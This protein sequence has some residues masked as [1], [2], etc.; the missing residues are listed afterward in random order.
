MTETVDAQVHFYSQYAGAIN[1]SSSAQ[2]D[3]EKFGQVLAFESVE[4][5]IFN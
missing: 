5:Q 2:G 4:K 1:I 3:E